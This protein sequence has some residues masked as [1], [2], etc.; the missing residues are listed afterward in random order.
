VLLDCGAFPIQSHCSNIVTHLKNI[1]IEDH[2]CDKYLD[3]WMSLNHNDAIR[4][5]CENTGSE[6]NSHN[7]MRPPVQGGYLDAFEQ[8]WTNE[9]GG[10]L[11]QGITLATYNPTNG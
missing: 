5:A 4:V 9:N 8:E 1:V 11:S 7:Y 3:K 10:D 6:A 2:D